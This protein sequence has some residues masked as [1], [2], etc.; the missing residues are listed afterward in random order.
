MYPNIIGKKYVNI[1]TNET[2][3]VTDQEN[4]IIT[5][6]DNDKVSIVRLMDKNIY[7]DFIDPAT[8]FG[9]SKSLD[10][11]SSKIM[12]VSDEVL[13]KMP[14]DGERSSS[15]SLNEVMGG[16]NNE[17]YQQSNESMLI[18]S[19]PDEEMRL[20]QEKVRQMGGNTTSTNQAR[21]QSERLLAMVSEVEP[22]TDDS[23]VIR[24]KPTSAISDLSEYRVPHSTEPIY[25]E[26][27]PV[28][29]P[30]ISMFNGVKRNVNFDITVSISK[31]IPR[32]DFIEMMEDS[33]NQS[34]I[35]YLASEFTD[36]L[37]R[38]PNLIKDI[39]KASISEMVYPP[40]KTTKTSKVTKPTQSKPRT[41]KSA[42]TS[43]SATTKRPPREAISNGVSKTR[44]NTKTKEIT[45]DRNNSESV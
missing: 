18:E 13:S 41:N 39:I 30:I 8:F 40:A 7:D 3:S 5:L 2:V 24:K 33:Y 6:N 23:P 35:D 22:Q 26:S 32:L 27:K 21:E 11:L 17:F 9:S 20:M 4:D 10:M 44:S 31:M 15:S 19:D 16:S 34:I 1:T 42:A 37:L 36:E 43:K 28:I 25:A 14:T 29:D 12:S 45:I 38:N